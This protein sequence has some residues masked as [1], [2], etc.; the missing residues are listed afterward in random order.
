MQAGFRAR[1]VPRP[2]LVEAAVVPDP[3]QENVALPRAH[4]L[5][6]L[7][8][9]EVAGQHAVAWLQP[10]D[11]ERPG[12]VEKHTPAYQ[13]VLE[14]L[15]GLHRCPGIRDRVRRPTVVERALPGDV[16]ERVEM[17]V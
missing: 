16:A 17:A 2:E 1:R 4:P 11:P 12:D 9:L 13:P 3:H 7:G 5:A 8:I 15:D 10:A 6:A 14:D